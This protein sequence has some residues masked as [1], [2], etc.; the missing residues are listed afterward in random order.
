MDELDS[1]VWTRNDA[2][3]DYRNDNPREIPEN[4]F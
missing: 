3:Q 2:C 1:S 4:D